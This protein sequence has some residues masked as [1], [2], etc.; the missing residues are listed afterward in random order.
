MCDDLAF[1]IFFSKQSIH[2][3]CLAVTDCVVSAENRRRGLGGE[4][5]PWEGDKGA[6]HAIFCEKTANE[7]ILPSV[8]TLHCKWQAGR[9]AKED[10]PIM[11]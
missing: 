11:I 1:C 7:D 3:S 6:P 4:D 8:T 2:N 9:A 10:W 5:G